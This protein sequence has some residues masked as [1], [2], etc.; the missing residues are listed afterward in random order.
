MER[1][2]E[3]LRRSEKDVKKIKWEDFENEL[4]R[5][6]SLYSAME[7]VTKRKRNLQQKLE[8]LIQVNAESLSR[9][10]ELED[11]RQRLE[12]RKLLVERTS[13]ACKVIEQD[14]KE[15]EERLG[16]KVKSLVIG[17]TS[18]SV[19]KSKSQDSNCQ[20]EGKRDYARLNAVMNKLRK[21]Q[22]NMILH[23]SCIYALKIKA[24]PSGDQELESFPSGS[25][26]GQLCTFEFTS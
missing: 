8:P 2:K 3:R 10:N 18:L 17:G 9:R 4:T 24:E 11:M 12:A 25:R 5:I 1:G 16:T 15:K 21:R 20:L 22:Q 23:V 7:E 13:A 19:A 14:A 6:L 26:S